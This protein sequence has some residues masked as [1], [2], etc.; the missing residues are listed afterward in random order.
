MKKLFIFLFFIFPLLAQGAL[1]NINTAGVEELKTLTGVGDVIAGR[2]IEYRSANGAFK[3]IEEIKN[4][5]GIGDATFAKMKDY[6]TVA[7]SANLPDNNVPVVPPANDLG[8][9]EAGDDSSAH[10][11]PSP[12]SNFL[13]ALPKV[14]AGRERL[15]TV[16]T[17]ID[18]VA[19]DN[20]K[21]GEGEQVTYIWSFGDG[22]SATGA[23]VS[24]AYNYAGTYNVVLNASYNN[25]DSAVARTRVTV[26]E[27]AVSLTMV[28]YQQGYLEI[29]NS[30]T[31]EQNIN[32]WFL[33]S[34]LAKYYFPLDTIISSQDKIKVPL[35]F[36]GPLATSTVSLYYPNGEMASE[37]KGSQVGDLTVLQ[38]QLR[39]LKA[40]LVL[41]Q[42]VGLASSASAPK[43]QNDKLTDDGSG[44][45]VLNKKQGLLSRW[46]ELIF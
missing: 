40:E 1:I 41:K 12:L 8:E 38:N 13:S 15:A 14:G 39:E 10:T 30:G 35:W 24:H 42:K 31:R 18:F 46:R 7:G 21:L 6:I 20:R 25:N 11:S 4:V 44:P 17:P 29:R 36:L 9:S 16:K 37:G 3:T 43:I 26:I 22:T 34:G 33:A 5:K 28:N 2:I 19:Y 32:G 45:I 23:K 27:S